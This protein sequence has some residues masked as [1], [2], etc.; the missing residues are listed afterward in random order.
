MYLKRPY[1]DK[2]GRNQSTMRFKRVKKDKLSVILVSYHRQF[3]ECLSDHVKMISQTYGD[4]EPYT[5]ISFVIKVNKGVELGWFRVGYKCMCFAGS[6][7]NK[8]LFVIRLNRREC[9]YLMLRLKT[10]FKTL[11]LKSVVH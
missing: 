2:S 4:S 1:G 7:K 9:S 10:G 11:N 3:M 8:N 5:V 6:I